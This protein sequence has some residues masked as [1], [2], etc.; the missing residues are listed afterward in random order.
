M[1]GGSSVSIVQMAYSAANVAC[2]AGCA[3]PIPTTLHLTNDHGFFA[4]AYNPDTNPADL[5]AGSW[6]VNY[7]TSGSVS[8]SVVDPINHAPHL[9][10]AAGVVD[11]DVAVTAMVRCPTPGGRWTVQYL[12][13][14]DT[15]FNQVLGVALLAAKAPGAYRTTFSYSPAVSADAAGCATAQTFAAPTGWAGPNPG[16][17]ALSS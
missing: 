16:R 6:W 15:T 12:V 11:G 3:A 9:V 2:C 17:G 13:E 8:A 10:P 5:T 7:T 4:L 14:T 1:A